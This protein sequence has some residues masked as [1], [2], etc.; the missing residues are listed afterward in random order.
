[1]HRGALVSV[2]R[3]C[4]LVLRDS[5]LSSLMDWSTSKGYH[6]LREHGFDHPA[7]VK[8]RSVPRGSDREHT[9][10]AVLQRAVT[11]LSTTR[12]PP[13]CGQAGG[14]S[15]TR[16]NESRCPSSPVSHSSCRWRRTGA[17][18]SPAR[19]ST[20]SSW[21]PTRWP[22]SSRLATTLRDHRGS[23]HW[24]S[25]STTRSAYTHR[26]AALPN[27]GS[28]STRRRVGRWRSRARKTPSAGR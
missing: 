13:C 20:E 10:V 16:W 4:G 9:Y 12:R 23:R 17:W 1:M 15:A 5:A 8:V 24:R 18:G 22:T 7:A 2:R 14:T 6:A 27:A 25:W 26:S 28:R 3:T 21:S 11:P 19:A